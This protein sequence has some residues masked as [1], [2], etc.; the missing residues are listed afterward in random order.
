MPNQRKKIDQLLIFVNLYQHAKNEAVSS[1][2]SGEMIDLKIL[3]S[4]WLKT[5]WPLSQEQDL[6]QT[7]N[8]CRNTANNI[9]LHYH[10]K[11]NSRKIN[12]QIFL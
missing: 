10:Y 8:L 9:N 2:C 6:S 12:D 4:E 5:F 11:T 3:Q 7:E 1:I